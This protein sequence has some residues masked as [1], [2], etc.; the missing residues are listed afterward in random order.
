MSD[1]AERL[2]WNLMA[3]SLQKLEDKQVTIDEITYEYSDK[4]FI[5]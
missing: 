2:L 5:F 3:I 1:M 4:L